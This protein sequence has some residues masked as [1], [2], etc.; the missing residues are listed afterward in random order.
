[1]WRLAYFWAQIIFMSDVGK[2]WKKSSL[3]SQFLKVKC[4][5]HECLWAIYYYGVATT[6]LVLN[7]ICRWWSAFPL[8][9]FSFAFL[10][11]WPIVWLPA[12]LPCKKHRRSRIYFS[13]KQ[14]SLWAVLWMASILRSG[15]TNLLRRL[16]PGPC[17]SSKTFSRRCRSSS[18][19]HFECLTDWDCLPVF[20]WHF[21]RC[22]FEPRKSASAGSVL[23]VWTHSCAGSQSS[24]P[25]GPG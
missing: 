12:F 5:D 8:S 16:L 23:A 24:P 10:S 22:R 20:W 6:A 17:L 21:S 1:M 14:A 9:S 7:Y 4:F 18:A 2:F 13:S 25:A 15:W 3:I 19:V 11:L